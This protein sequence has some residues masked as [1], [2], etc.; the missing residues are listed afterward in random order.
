[1]LSL[2]CFFHFF[3][4]C[5][6]E[7]WSSI[8]SLTILYCCENSAVAGSDVSTDAKPR[9]SNGKI[10]F[11]VCMI[12]GNKGLKDKEV[13]VCGLTNRIGKIT[14]LPSVYDKLQDNK[15]GIYSSCHI[16]V[17]LQA[18]ECLGIVSNVNSSKQQ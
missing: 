7:E 5:L 4:W 14:M 3:E 8:L 6:E 15:S 10:S 12:S 9:Y 11:N 1:M 18:W 2:F 13:I 16:Y 17:H